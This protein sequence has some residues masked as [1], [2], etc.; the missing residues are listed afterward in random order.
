MKSETHYH[1]RWLTL[2]QKSF[3]S[4]E[5]AGKLAEQT[6]K[7]NESYV[8]EECDDECEICKVSKANAASPFL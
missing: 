2:D 1:I 7:R 6:K 4:S 5:E 3:S 8:I